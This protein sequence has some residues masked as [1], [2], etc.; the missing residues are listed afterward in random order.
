MTYL[1][2]SYIEKI[3]TR[4][5]DFLEILS[6]YEVKIYTKVLYKRGSYRL[7][8]ILSNHIKNSIRMFTLKKSIE[9]YSLRPFLRE[10]VGGVIC[11]LMRPRSLTTMVS[12]LYLKFSVINT[13]NSRYLYIY[14]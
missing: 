5:F 8:R 10:K 4:Y 2:S 7:L 1:S 12:L 6:K 14:L 13:C 11:G 9:L 3:T